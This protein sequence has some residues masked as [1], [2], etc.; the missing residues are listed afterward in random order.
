[1]VTDR[2]G[3]PQGSEE[4]ATTAASD[5]ELGELW[6]AYRAE[7]ATL[8]RRRLA[9][10]ISV[11]LLVVGMGIVAEA[12]AHPAR[13]RAVVASY[14]LLVLMCAAGLLACQR[15]RLEGWLDGVGAVVMLG[16]SLAL[17]SYDG[18]VGASA[19]R[20]AMT[21]L[22]LL[23]GLVVMLPW[24]WR[25]Q[26]VVALGSLL[27]F[28]LAAP[29]LAAAD[30]LLY[31]SSALAIGA[32]TSLAG[33]F[34]LG[35]HRWD[36]FRR[37]ALLRREADIASALMHVAETLNAHLDDP[38]MLER[39]NRLAVELL[40]C[41]CSS[42]FSWDASRQAFRLHANVGS[43]PE[44]VR[45]LLTLELPRDRLPGFDALGAG[46]LLEIA[47]AR[48]Q[49]L[50]P[51]GLLGRL[52]V[53]S[54]LCVPVL[55]RGEVIAVLVHG[56]RGHVGPFTPT[57]QRLAVGIGHA[58]AIALK[59]ASL[60][61]DAHTA[62]RLKSEFVSTMSHELR[63]PINVIAGYSYL[64]E[65]GTFDPLTPGQ[66]DTVERIAR[67]AR[68]LLDLVT[69][70]LDMNRLEAGRDPLV[71]AAVDLRDLLGELGRELEPLVR[72]GVVLRW[73]NAL[74]STPIVSDRAKLKTILKNLMGNALKFTSAG[75]VD[76][77]ASLAGDRL[78]LEVSDTGMGIAPQDLP[79]IFEMLRQGDGSDSRRAGG[80]GLGLHIVRR[81]VELLGGTISVC[82]TLERGSRFT[83]VIPAQRAER[84]GPVPEAAPDAG[85]TGADVGELRGGRLACA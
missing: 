4:G 27:S 65:Q 42:T 58:T 35:R 83:V 54:A 12:T 69:A 81:L 77:A 76:V 73:R 52:E 8:I 32:T 45:E 20:A 82:S 28:A 9:L 43:P 29:H 25:P 14:G 19:E 10:A 23:T 41:D 21:Q 22:C 40:G 30:P 31:A 11:L 48:C 80:V 57:Q 61:A 36:A 16:V 64:L 34:F 50:V 39:V 71:H 51:T 60:V 37:A 18:R 15:P 66:Q 75:T 70:T 53:S 3:V 7:T 78:T 1:M 59:N 72:E 74:G 13:A 17:A 68:E 56:H 63:T 47:D 2:Y 5:R 67:S 49:E 79:V 6:G 26:L 38:R 46:A 24:G 55:R 44:V 62:S 33:A 84:I 85:A